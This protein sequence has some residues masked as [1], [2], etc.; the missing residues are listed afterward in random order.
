[1]VTIKEAVGILKYS[2]EYVIIDVQLMPAGFIRG[3]LLNDIDPRRPYRLII[4]PVIENKRP[5]MRIWIT[6]IIKMQSKAVVKALEHSRKSL[7]CGYVA[8]DLRGAVTFRFWKNMDISAAQLVILLDKMVE[9]VQLFEMTLSFYSMLDSG[10]PRN[11]VKTIMKTYFPQWKTIA[12][13]VR[14]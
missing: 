1:M 9:S 3:C 10:M 6:S 14:G 2:E 11:H 12:D 4:H 13:R 8:I 7:T 5:S